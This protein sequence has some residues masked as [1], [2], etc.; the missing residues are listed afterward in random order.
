MIS[1][2][3]LYEQS[4]LMARLSSLAYF[5]NQSFTELGY[6]SVFIDHNDSQAY[7]LWDIDD[8]ILVSRG[9]QPTELADIEAD[10]QFNLVQSIGQHGLVHYGFKRSVDHV[11]S[12]MSALLTKYSNRKVWC[13]GHSL[14][15]AMATIISARCCGLKNVAT[16]TL[17]TFGSP[18]VGNQ[19]YV[20]Y[21]SSQGIEHY[22]WVNSADVVAR[23]PIAPY[24]HHGNLCYFDH[25]GRL[26]VRTEWQRTKDRVKGFFAGLRRGSV[27]L[28]ANH[29]IDGYITNI[30]KLTIK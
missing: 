16:P 1:Q 11:W 23:N 26:A 3:T 7:V 13:T 5:D 15:A 10:I 20:N 12:D 22:R 9:T 2:L 24:K 6:D 4:L 25:H 29:M 8:I 19:D 27:S 18:R 14:G 30:D 28:F 17:F 21:L